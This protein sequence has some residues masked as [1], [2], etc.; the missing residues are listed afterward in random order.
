MITNTLAAQTHP[1]YSIGHS[2]RTQETFIALLQQ[3]GVSALAD[4]RTMPRSR[5]NPQFNMEE[6]ESILPAAGV[7]YVRMEALAG[8]RKKRRDLDPVVNGY[9]QNQSFHNYAD[10]ALTPEFEA[11]L[12]ALIELGKTE[13][14]AFMCAEAVWWRCHRRIIADYLLTAGARV[15]HI[16]DEKPP[17]PAERNP[18]ATPV[19]GGGLVYPAEGE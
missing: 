1:F 10:Y 13:T 17:K 12:L 6:L 4:V 11:G 14:C 18:A 16:I 19:E 15:F 3:N 7:K 5:A 9:W 8:F 2:T